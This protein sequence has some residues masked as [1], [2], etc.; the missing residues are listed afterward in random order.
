LG[1]KETLSLGYGTVLRIPGGFS[2]GKGTGIAAEP[3]CQYGCDQ[4]A[5]DVEAKQEYGL[6][7]LSMHN[8]IVRGKVERSIFPGELSGITF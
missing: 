8:V 1:E 6:F 3:Q 7:S 4:Q 2:P 5:E